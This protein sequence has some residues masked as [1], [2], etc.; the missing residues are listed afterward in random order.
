MAD[1]P[2]SIVQL[3]QALAAALGVPDPSRAAKVELTLQPGAMPRVVA[4]FWLHAADGLNQ[5]VDSWDLVPQR[6]LALA[7]PEESRDAA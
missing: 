2:L 5:V 6:T 3:N 1:Q 7:V 4:T